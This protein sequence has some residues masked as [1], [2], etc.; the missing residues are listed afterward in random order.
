MDQ[1]ETKERKLVNNH[2]FRIMKKN[3]LGI[4]QVIHK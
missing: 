1:R 2:A 3:L 4:E